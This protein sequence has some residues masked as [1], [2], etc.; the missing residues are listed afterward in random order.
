MRMSWQI[1]VDGMK[2]AAAVWKHMISVPPFGVS[3]IPATDV[4]TTASL[5]KEHLT[6]LRGERLSGDSVWSK[7]S[8]QFTTP[9][10]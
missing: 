8:L 6:L 4:A 3:D 10:P 9:Q 7:R 5:V 1:I 2:P